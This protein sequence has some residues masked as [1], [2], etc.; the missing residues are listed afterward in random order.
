MPPGLELFGEL[1][2]PTAPI[3]DDFSGRKLNR[4][5]RVL[6]PPRVDITIDR[7]HPVTSTNAPTS[8]IARGT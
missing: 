8:A 6:R 2:Y 5:L 1:R 4:A 7:V 3:R